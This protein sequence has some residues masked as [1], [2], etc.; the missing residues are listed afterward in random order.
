MSLLQSDPPAGG[1]HPHEVIVRAERAGRLPRPW[2]WAIYESNRPDALHRS[3]R[4]YRS[5]EEAW[6]VGNKMLVLLGR[7]GWRTPQAPISKAMSA[8]AKVCDEVTA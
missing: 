8:S 4:S 1:T 5:A 3:S 7:R 6:T 2:I